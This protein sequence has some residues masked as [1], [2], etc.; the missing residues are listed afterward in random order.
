MFQ[1]QPDQ[2]RWFSEPKKFDIQPDKDYYH[3]SWLGFLA[4][5]L[6]VSE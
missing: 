2:A 4:K 1:F 5:D 6:R 3:R